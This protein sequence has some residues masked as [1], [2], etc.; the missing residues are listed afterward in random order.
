M[1]RQLIRVL[2]LVVLGSFAAGVQG[3]LRG[4]TAATAAEKFE[5][6]V[7]HNVAAKMRDGVT[8]RADIYRPKADGKFPVLLERTPY[9]KSG[10]RDFGMRG[11]ARGYVVVGP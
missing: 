6:T 2:V 3:E 9:D 11:A 5:V 7:E 8:L 10:G 4:Q 1:R